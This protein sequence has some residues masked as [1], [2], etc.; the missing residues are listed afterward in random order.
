[1]GADLSTG[2][3][4][5][6]LTAMGFSVAE[7]Q[8]ALEATGGDVQAAAEL[9]V[10]RRE[11]RERDAGGVV[12]VRINEL[13]RDQRPWPEFFG[14]FL[15]P[16]HLAER[17]QTNLVYYRAK[18]AR[19]RHTVQLLF[20]KPAVCVLRSYAILSAGVC[21]VCVLMQPMVLIIACLVGAAFY[22]AVEWGDTRP[23][24]VL[25]QPLVF[26]QR[27]TAAALASAAII[28]MSGTFGH[29]ARVTLLCGGLTLAHATFRARTLAARWAHFKERA[30][31]SE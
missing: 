2:R 31:K 29:V 10:Q 17:V 26:E 14:R 8:M 25:E 18:Y 3:A 21:L 24:P 27:V 4:L 20:T 6:Q 15:W 19:P 28:H 16:E 30:E 9:L 5:T 22:G 12:A 11:A 23:I 7:S 1:M 13:L